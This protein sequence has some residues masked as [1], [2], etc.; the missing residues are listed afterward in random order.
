MAQ[1]RDVDLVEV[2]SAAKPPVCRLLDY[3]KFLYE[4][5]KKE[6]LARK[7]QRVIDIKEI[8]MHP[9][10]ASHDIAFKTKRIREF[11]ADGAKVRLRVRF[12]G[13]Q[14][15][16][17]KPGQELLERVVAGLSDIAIVEQAPTIEE[18]A[19]SVFVLLAPKAPERRRADVSSE[20]AAIMP[21]ATEAE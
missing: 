7:S 15:S 10:S 21:A 5:T 3:G 1:E 9:Q 4:R 14:K 13:R 6:R 16:N 11:L 2:A 12:R 19:S 18:G 17:P 8:W 20:A